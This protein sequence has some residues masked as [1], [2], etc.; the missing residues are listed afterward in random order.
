MS[1]VLR[2]PHERLFFE[3]MNGLLARDWQKTVT[4]ASEATRL[5]PT[6]YD[7]YN[8]LGIASAELGRKDE[9][10]KAFTTF[11]KFDHNTIEAARAR[12]RLDKIQNPNPTGG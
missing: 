11:L 12:Q 10:V 7:F 6:F 4:A 9:A 5:Y 3:S 8:H 2:D 1:K